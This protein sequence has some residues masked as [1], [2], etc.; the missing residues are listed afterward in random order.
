M[1]KTPKILQSLTYIYMSVY[2][3]VLKKMVL[4]KKTRELIGTSFLKNSSADSLFHN[5]R[6]DVELWSNQFLNVVF[7]VF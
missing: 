1:R 3:V 4:R 7:K 6:S 2:K 5:P